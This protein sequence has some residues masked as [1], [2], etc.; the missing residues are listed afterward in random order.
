MN[1]HGAGVEDRKL[2]VGEDHEF[3]AGAQHPKDVLKCFLHFRYVMQDAVRV[4]D[5]EC[6]VFKWEVFS[7]ARPGRRVS[8]RRTQD[9][10]SFWLHFQ[11]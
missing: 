11:A 5:M 4:N 1:E 9:E 2:V 3:A 6:I 10:V 8:S 7:V